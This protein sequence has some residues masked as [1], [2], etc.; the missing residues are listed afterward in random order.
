MDQ[1][2]FRPDFLFEVSWEV[3]NK[4]GG[5]HTAISSRAHIPAGRLNDN[6]ILIGPDVW[7]E[8]R[9]NPEFTEDP[10]MFRSWKRFA[11]KNGIKVKTG[12]WNIPGNPCVILVDFTPYFQ[13][14]DKVLAEFWE[15]YGLD[16]LTG[17]WNYIEPALFGYAAG[18]VIESFYEYNISARNT[19]AVHSHEWHTGTTVLYLKKNVPQ[20]SLVYT[21]YSTVIGRMLASSGRYN[22]IARINVDEETNR[23]GI[24]AQQSLESLAAAHTDI[25]TTLSEQLNIEC[26]KTLGRKADVI[27]SNGLDFSAIPSGDLYDQLRDKSRNKILTVAEAITNTRIPADSFLI[28]HSG[29]Y[30]FNNKGTDVFIRALPEIASQSQQTVVAI[31]C[32]PGNQTG[33]R[34][35]VVER[36]HNC[37]Y[38]VPVT[39]EFLTHNLKDESN[40]P[41]ISALRNAGI[42][43]D[44]SSRIKVVFVPTYLNGEDGVFNISYHHLL[45][46]FDL[47]VLPSYYDPWSHTP[48][49]SIALSVPSVTSNM[50]GFASFILSQKKEAPRCTMMVD[51]QDLPY[52]EVV[53]QT[54]QFINNYLS[55]SNEEQMQIRKEARELAGIFAWENFIDRYCQSHEDACKKS[56]QRYELYKNKQVAE[57]M[58]VT[59]TG[60]NQNPVWKKVFIKS[61]I[62][63]RIYPLQLIAKNIWWSWNYDAQELF[64][65][66]DPGLWSEVGH[67]P[68]LMLESMTASKFNELE[69]N[70]SFLE[71][72]DQVYDRFTRYMGTAPDDSENVVAY[73]SMEFGLHDTIKIYSGGLGVLAGDYLK[74]ASDSNKAMVGIGLLYRYGYF[75]QSLTVNGEQVSNYIPQKFSNL[76]LVP[77]RDEKNDWIMVHF[78]FPGR[79]VHAKVWKLMVGRVPLFLLDTDIE[80]NSEPDRSITH[81]LYGGDWENRLKQEIVLGIGGVKLLRQLGIQPSLYHCNEGHAALLVL[82]RVKKLIE[83]DLFSFSEAVEI[84][85]AT[86]LF[87]THTPVPAGHDAFSEDMLRTYLSHYAEKMN[88]E[89][90]A[91][92][93]LGRV[94]ENDPYEKFSMSVLAARLSQDVNGVSRIHGRVS[95]E[96]FNNMWSG[97]YPEELHISY[98]TNGV[99]FPT[100]VSRTALELYQEYLDAEILT[101]Q[102]EPEVWQKIHEVPDTELWNLRQQLRQNLFIY[103]RRKMMANIQNRQESPKLTLE[104]IEKLNDKTLTIGFARR[105]ATYKRAHLIFHNLEKLAMLVNNPERP[106]Q[107]IFAGKAH[108]HDKAGQDLIKRIVEV[109][110]MPQFLGKVV[111]IED[112]DMDLAKM[113]I[114]G[115]DVWLNNPTRPLEASGTS[116]EKAIMNGVVNCSVLDGWWAEGYVQDAGWA[117]KEERTYQNQDLQDELDAET[118]YHLFENEI[119]QAFYNRNT[120]G[121]PEKWVMHM[122]NTIAGIS[123]RFTMRRQLD[124][125][126][127]QFYLP[128]FERRKTIV[129]GDYEMIRQLAR[130]KQKVVNTWDKIEVVNIE[131]PDSTVKPLLLT[132]SFRASVILDLKDLSAEEVGVEVVFG[133][134]EFDVVKKIH[135]IEE[136]KTGSFHNG[137]VEY[138]C[139]IPFV[140]SGVYDYSFRVFPR[141]KMLKYR[142]D[143][144]LVKWI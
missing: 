105:F 82:E 63:E 71:K 139:D 102:H 75:T 98:V 92:V 17:G 119:T 46:G 68:L 36:I 132:E 74:E 95:R 123:P 38:Q 78:G 9:S 138:T 4:I 1:N 109:S 77:V 90:K 8:T 93:G 7:K 22:E 14:K 30:D 58:I 86:T 56:K 54:I 19:L 6:Y 80:E 60:M 108:P 53:K 37:D 125:Y 67:N 20:A 70:K 94:N 111:F 42:T 112:Y 134:K 117:L 127:R 64:E 13:I 39:G 29:L 65:Q 106:I 84:V 88:V 124:D 28:L 76:P 51:R 41:V 115:V 79:V 126:Y 96:M 59:D 72:L 21:A 47:S 43:N 114:Q 144:P 45:P 12:R 113:L 87:T 120:Q 55:F 141:N 129:A 11:E 103:L 18:L 116:G 107:F 25:F 104:R 85:K 110:R 133:Q 52:E 5:I 44:P 130:W 143:F 32:H 35:P 31:I 89:W 99:H 15:T 27:I 122:K 26:E 142:Q 140:R 33:P 128:A 83:R 62:P 24:R 10:Y 91:L 118:L 73:F 2:D 16:S 3:C 101:R 136:L 61:F 135:F 49:E 69:K 137:C 131:I 57:Q 34:I 100:W 50:T 66:I 97:F 121:I 81:Q 48:M 23:Y 40:D